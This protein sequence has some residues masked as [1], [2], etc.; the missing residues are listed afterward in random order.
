METQQWEILEEI[1]VGLEKLAT[2]V[3]DEGQLNRYVGM[4]ETFAD[5]SRDRTDDLVLNLE[6]IAN[7]VAA[8]L[9]QLRSRVGDMTTA[10]IEKEMAAILN[11][12][13][14]GIG[15]E[16]ERNRHDELLM[17]LLIRPDAW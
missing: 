10:A 3:L 15:T 17:E 11:R 13:R 9:E 1:E 5:E 2:S 4:T 8:I 12:R 14:E 7:Q 6:A 16:E